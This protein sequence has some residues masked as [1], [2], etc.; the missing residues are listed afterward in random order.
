[1]LWRE[2]NRRTLDHVE[3]SASC[4]A[5]LVIDTVRVQRLALVPLDP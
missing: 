4:L 1:L 3:R 5:A 2:R